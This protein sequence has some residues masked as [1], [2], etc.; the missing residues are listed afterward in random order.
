VER[1]RS[2]LLK[3]RT[4]RMPDD[5]DPYAQW[6]N[7][8]AASRPIDHYR[9]LG[10]ER[11][12]SDPQKIAAAADARMRHVR[13]FQTGPRGIY[14]QKLLNEL[15]AA[16][17]QLL[18]AATK[19]RYDQQLRQAPA[20]TPSELDDGEDVVLPPAAGDTPPPGAAA[21][22][23]PPSL[24]PAPATPHAPLADVVPPLPVPVRATEVR[25]PAGPARR[26]LSAWAYFGLFTAGALAIAAAVWLLGGGLDARRSPDRSSD[27]PPQQ[28]MPVAAESERETIAVQQASG[29]VYL[30]PHNAKIH[31]ASPKLVGSGTEAAITD[32]TNADDWLSWTF[33]VRRGGIFRLR[34]TYAVGADAA[35]GR[36]AFEIDDNTKQHD[37]R[38]SGGPDSFITDEILIGAREPGRHTLALRA[39]HKPGD[40]VLIFKAIE[41]EPFRPQRPG[42]AD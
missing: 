18:N 40:Q 25:A 26:G 3:D 41:I 31:G 28:A 34:L 12:E 32:W 8:D 1:G 36:I 39:V 33:L 10:L 20:H 2:L 6:L 13:S 16:K 29:L 37:L 7:I 4:P 9:L 19:Q 30:T 38:A 14:T 21:S 15:A 27:P 5:F 22:A 42:S 23:P 11:F 24:P 17:L 35:K